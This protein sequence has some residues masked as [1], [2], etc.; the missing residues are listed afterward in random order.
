MPEYLY[1]DAEGHQVTKRHR[2]LYTT[3]IICDDCGGPMWRKPQPVA[4]NWGGLA[5]S[6]GEL[7]PELQ[8]LTNESERQRRHDALEKELEDGQ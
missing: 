5:P 7:A 4:I 6:Q 1:T 2:M 3:G 8:R